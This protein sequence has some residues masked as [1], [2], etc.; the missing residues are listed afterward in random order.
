M[1]NPSKNPFG[2]AAFQSGD[3]KPAALGALFGIASL[4]GL[5][6]AYSHG[7]HVDPFLAVVASAGLFFVGMPIL[8]LK[9]ATWSPRARW[10]TELLG[11][12]L[13]GPVCIVILLLVGVW[14]LP[15]KEAG[16]A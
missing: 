14:P 5:W 6:Y 7:A 9:K 13:A 4:F 3:W 10:W 15:W 16:G 11:V 2:S 8:L 12:C 1:A